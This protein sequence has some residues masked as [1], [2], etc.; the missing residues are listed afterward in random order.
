M[1]ANLGELN[2]FTHDHG[3]GIITDE[4]FH[5]HVG[6]MALKATQRTYPGGTFVRTGLEISKDEQGQT[7]GAIEARGGFNMTE[8]E[9][10]DAAQYRPRYYVQTIP[11]WD[12]D[13]ADNGSSEVQFWNF[14]ARRTALYMK[15]MR[16]RFSRHMYSKG[17]G[18]LQINGFGDIFDNN[19]VFGMIDRSKYDWWRS[20]IYSNATPRAATTF[21]LATMLSAVSDGDIEPDILLTSTDMYDRYEA[22]IDPKERF[23]NTMLANAGFRNITYRGIPIVKDKNCDTD[24]DQRHKVYA[25]NFDHIFWTSH[26]MFNMKKRD[27]MLMPKNLGQFMVV[28]W[29]GNIMPNSLRR[30]GMLAD[31]NPALA[32]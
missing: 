22:L 14:V 17:G 8:V 30:Q 7:G 21:Q 25:L 9:G 11:L 16:E 28:V 32:A 3:D 13:V 4:V 2:A 12:S 10:H 23:P 27:W 31:L 5:K 26:V 6:L 24:G 20:Y 15:F 29:F 1:A 19:S 18:T